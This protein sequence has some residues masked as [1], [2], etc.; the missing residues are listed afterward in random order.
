MPLL[1]TA[2]VL[3]TPL[4]GFSLSPPPGGSPPHPTPAPRLLLELD[5]APA[6]ATEE[7]Q[8]GL[9]EAIRRRRELADYHRAFGIATWASMAVTAVLGVIQLYDEY[10]FLDGEGTT[11]CDRGGAVFG[12]CGE[13]QFPWA[14]AIAGGVTTTLYSAT[15]VLSLSMPDPLDVASSDTELGEDLRIHRA[16]RWVHLAGM[17]VL[18]T[19][20]AVSANIE[21]DY[22]VRRGLAW[23]HAST[24]V[25][26]F[27]TMTAAGAIMLF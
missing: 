6:G 23:A 9:A 16:L 10:G 21:A 7:D 13:R 26:T 1:A 17:V 27:G 2:L 11:P 8:A 22:E 14:H 19:L 24:A 25:V 3:A 15:F 18:L 20:G 5:D 4:F 12:W